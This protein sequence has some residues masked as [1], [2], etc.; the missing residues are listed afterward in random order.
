MSHAPTEYNSLAGRMMM[1]FRESF[2]EGLQVDA[3]HAL[4]FAMK[5]LCG[6]VAAELIALDQVKKGIT[7]EQAC[8]FLIEG[9]EGR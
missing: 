4:S 3:D 7:L 8:R 6:H 2:S 5:D 9:A 1:C